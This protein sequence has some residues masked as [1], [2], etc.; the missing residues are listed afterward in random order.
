MFAAID[1]DLLGI[2]LPI[3]L[4]VVLTFDK[5]NTGDITGLISILSSEISL[6]ISNALDIESERANAHFCAYG[7]EFSIPS[8]KP[9][10][11]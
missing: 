9:L 7:I 11:I 3:A 2:S 8:P 10:P 5:S 4:A 1:I 6:I